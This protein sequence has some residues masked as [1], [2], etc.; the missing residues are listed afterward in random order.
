MKGEAELT[1]ETINY[2]EEQV[3]EQSIIAQGL[4]KERSSHSTKSDV[5]MEQPKK[6]VMLITDKR[7]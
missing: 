2:L 1:Q 5:P 7:I 3:K 4:Q 6:S